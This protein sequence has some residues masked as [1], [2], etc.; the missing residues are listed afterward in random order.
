MKLLSS[1]LLAAAP[2]LTLGTLFQQGPP[3]EEPPVADDGDDA[4]RDRGGQ[5]AS[6]LDIFGRPTRARRNS[7]EDRLLGV[8]TLLFQRGEVPCLNF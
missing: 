5:G 2:A 3:Q 8:L 6:R 4:R 7:L 1:L